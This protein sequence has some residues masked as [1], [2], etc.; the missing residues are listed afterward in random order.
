M[1]TIAAAG[2]ACASAL[3]FARL[4]TPDTLESDV[5]RAIE[6]RSLLAFI[7]ADDA[8]LTAGLRLALAAAAEVRAD[9][10]AAALRF[11]FPAETE[12]NAAFTRLPALLFAAL[13]LS[14][15]AWAAHSDAQRRA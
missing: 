11:A 3:M 15:L 5:T 1:L 8:L 12:A 4:V 10:F 7:T 14:R 13:A 6:P 2:A 9:V